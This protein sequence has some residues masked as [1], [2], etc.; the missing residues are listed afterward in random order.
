MVEITYENHLMLI[1]D[2]INEMESNIHFRENV[3]RCHD[4][5][6]NIMKA[7][8]FNDTRIVASGLI[9]HFTGK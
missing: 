6:A 7:L 9:L 4:R 1:R 5:M 8:I 2:I 3:T